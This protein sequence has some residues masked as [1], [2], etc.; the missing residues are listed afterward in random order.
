M[1]HSHEH[2]PGQ[3]HQHT[4][5]THG[6]L[7]VGEKTIYLSHLPMFTDPT[8]S[9]Q[10]ILEVTLARDGEDPHAAYLSD[11]RQT[12]ASIYSVR[13][14]EFDIA[15]LEPGHPQ[16]ITSF[17]G[18]LFRN[19]FE[20]QGSEEILPGLTFNVERVVVFR[21]LPAPGAPRGLLD[22]RL[23]G[24]GTDLFLSHTIT[25]APDFDQTLAVR[26][27]GDGPSADALREALPIVVRGRTNHV[28]ERLRGGERVTGEVIEGPE[29]QAYELE[30]VAEIY[31]EEGELRD[32]HTFDPTPE[33]VAAGMP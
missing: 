2:E 19:H 31:L 23:Y 1:D 6:M 18:G 28:A 33:E 29:S 8:H 5:G 26:V 12:G 27:V 13:P 32:P 7:L 21:E 25:R 14:D 9:F 17:T 15:C 22:Y 10:V 4:V 11:R 30:I 16:C 24:V 3:G 20:R